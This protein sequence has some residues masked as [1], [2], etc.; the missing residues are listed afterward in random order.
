M[1][2]SKNNGVIYFTRFDLITDTITP[3]LDF[4]F[5]NKIRANSFNHLHL[6]L[7][8]LRQVRGMISYV[9]SSAGV[10]YILLSA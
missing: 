8:F 3:F 6:I 5:R 4:V 7:C 1:R 9:C 10:V 2:P